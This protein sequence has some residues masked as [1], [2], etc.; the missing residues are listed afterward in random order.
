M[1]SLTEKIQQLTAL[2]R[3]SAVKPQAIMFTPEEFDAL[4]DYFES[5]GSK[6]DPER[7]PALS[8][9]APDAHRVDHRPGG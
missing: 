7:Y 6:P 1:K 4:C 9:S 8:H 2:Y 3:K 5:G